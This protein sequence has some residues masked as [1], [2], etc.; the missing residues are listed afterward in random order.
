M[1]I[2]DRDDTV[3]EGYRLVLDGRRY[4][5]EFD[6]KIFVPYEEGVKAVVELSLIHIL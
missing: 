6:G 2:R 3:G 1:C 5:K 4:R